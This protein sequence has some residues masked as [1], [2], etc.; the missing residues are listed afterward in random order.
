MAGFWQCEDT[1]LGRAAGATGRRRSVVVA[2]VVAAAFSLLIVPAAAANGFNWTGD[3]DGHSW[4]DAGNWGGSGV[5]QDGDSVTIGPSK[6]T[7]LP[8]VTG[9]PAI[10]LKDL[11]F[12]GAGLS[13]GAVTVTGTFSWDRG[14]VGIPLTIDGSGSASGSNTHELSAGPFIVSSGATFTVSPGTTIFAPT[15]CVNPYQFKNFGTLI[16]PP[17][18]VGTATLTNFEVDDSG[19]IVVGPGST[20]DLLGDAPGTFAA[21]TSV[22]GGGS[23]LLDNGTPISLTGRLSIGSGTTVQ[24]GSTGETYGPDLSGAASFVGN[25]SFVWQGGSI[26]GKLGVASTITTTITGPDTKT[27]LGSASKGQGTLSVAGKTTMSGSGQLQFPG[28]GLLNNTGTLSLSPGTTIAALTCCVSPAKLTNSGTL[29]VPASS[30][31]TATVSSTAFEGA[32]PISIGKGSTLDLLGDAPSTLAAGVAVGGG[33]SLALENGTPMS[34]A[35]N[36]SV[37]AGTTLRLGKSGEFYGPSIGGTG[38]LIGAGGFLW[39]GGSISGKLSVAST[40]ATSISG[41]DA[42]LLQGLTA[43]TGALTLAGPTTFA[44]SGQIQY[45]GNGALTNSGTFTMS[46]G[47][48]MV[49]INTPG[50]FDNT[51]KLVVPA[52]TSGTATLNGAGLVFQDAGPISIG[53]GSTLDLLGDAGGSFAAGV[54]VGG[55]GSLALENGTP[56]SLAGNMSVAAGTTLRLGKSGEFYGPSIGGTGSL[57]GAGGFLWLGGSI[58]GKLSV[59]STIATSISGPDAK[60]LQGLTAGTGALTLAGPTTFAGSGQIQYRGNG[61]LTNSG[62]FTMSP[63]T[64]MVTINTPGKLQNTGTLVVAAPAGTATL[65]FVALDNSGHVKLTAG[66]LAVNGVGYTQTA[67]STQLAGGNLSSD[68]PLMASGGTVSGHG[69]ITGSL[70]NGATVRPAA[71]GG[72]LEIDGSYQQ[73]STGTL[74]TVIGGTTPG[75]GFGQLKVTKAATLAGSINATARTGYD[76]PVGHLFPVLTYASLTGM[77]SNKTGAPPYAVTYHASVADVV[78]SASRLR[79]TPAR[80]LT[81]ELP[82]A[83]PRRRADAPER[84]AEHRH[85]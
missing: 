36:V 61:A 65:S 71:T 54:A 53:K 12:N 17:S 2:I 85:R 75:N 1:R 74:A 80:R 42:K 8:N 13:G 68:R 32:G 37:A 83:R 69:L 51:G 45:R 50:K 57:I 29:T 5:P 20:L 38:S 31:G 46:P 26:S 33:G 82:N 21:G 47:T 41:P 4:S 15:C 60:L 72:I 49:T 73:T 55:G 43:G 11:S 64:S 52:S 59:A 63:G 27:L 23:L 84:P 3:G 56:M 22:E 24:L 25:G 10:S 14:N 70:V 16:V 34:L 67:G 76:P 77:F 81:A 44:G 7:P 48:S 78:F 39:L 62:T 66:T 19:A 79:G 6:S 28:D 58:S 35:G 40:I 30:A 9:V 18:I